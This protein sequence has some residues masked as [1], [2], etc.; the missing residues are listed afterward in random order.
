MRIHGSRIGGRAAAGANSLTAERESEACDGEVLCNVESC[1]T[2]SPA[3]KVTS[4]FGGAF[5]RIEELVRAQ[6]SVRAGMFDLLDLCAKTK[7]S[8]IWAR[9]QDLDLEKDQEELTKWLRKL[10]ECE[11]P[12]TTVNGLWFG[13]FNPYLDDGRPTSCL[14]LA[15][16]ERFDASMSDPDW[17]CGPEYF[18][19]GRYS[20]SQVLTKI[21][22]DSQAAP[23]D[24]GGQAEYTLC[25]GYSSL[26]IAE[27][28]RGALRQE[29]LG[30]ASFRGV[31]AG[32]DSGDA[33]LLDIL[34][35]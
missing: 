4:M 19:E 2:K 29:L 16:S 8:P 15:G 35:E 6:T 14:Y 20:S 1:T 26:V 23:D 25:L 9:F 31:A 21:Y 10:L 34:R 18:P 33:L 27:W 22:R 13:L 7:P 30:S 5:E 17:A 3:T 28:C 24:V 11:P 32:F 12:P